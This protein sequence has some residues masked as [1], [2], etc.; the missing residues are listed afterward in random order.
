MAFLLP[1]IIVL[2]L[3][4]NVLKLIFH[5]EIYL[6]LMQERI[7]IRFPYRFLIIFKIL[8]IQTI[9]GDESV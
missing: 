4:S 3:P 9:L 5:I 2:V 7:T 1:I 8:K 6:M